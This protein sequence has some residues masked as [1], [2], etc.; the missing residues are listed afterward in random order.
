MKKYFFFVLF[1]SA[2]LIFASE[3]DKKNDVNRE[4]KFEDVRVT[5][6]N[7]AGGDTVKIEGFESPIY[8]KGNMK[9]STIDKF[10]FNGEIKFNVDRSGR[11]PL[12][13]LLEMIVKSKDKLSSLSDITLKIKNSEPI[14]ITV[15]DKKYSPKKEKEFLVYTL[16]SKDTFEND[17]YFNVLAP[18]EISIQTI[19]FDW[20][21]DIELKPSE[22]TIDFKPPAIDFK[23]EEKFIELTVFFGKE[24]NIKDVGVLDTNFTKEEEIAFVNAIKKGTV[25]ENVKADKK[26]ILAFRYSNKI[27]NEKRKAEKLSKKKEG[28]TITIGGESIKVESIK[29]GGKNPGPEIEGLDLDKMKTTDLIHLLI[30]SPIDVTNDNIIVHKLV[31]RGKKVIPELIKVTNIKTFKGRGY[32]AWALAFVIRVNG[33]VKGDQGT[34]QLCKLLKD[35]NRYVKM[36]SASGLN[37]INDKRTIY[38]LIKNYKSSIGN[39]KITLKTL[40]DKW[41]KS[42]REAKKW[43]KK[44]KDKYPAQF[45]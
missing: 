11:F 27:A 1:F 13:K 26:N 44:N 6:I 20:S 10:T 15:K 19:T 23:D 16:L 37:G 34:I 28:T 21:K 30:D 43:W 35:R 18:Q 29:K 5:E 9:Y 3:I 36:L 8:L 42:K 32:S 41:F 40:T 4:K 31:D 33:D 7:F 17:I 12:N 2:I 24:K 22:K 25:S 39:F 45:K 14:T 38:P